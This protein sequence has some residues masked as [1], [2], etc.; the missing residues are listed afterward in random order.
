MTDFRD[1]L[2][3]HPEKKNKSSLQETYFFNQGV[4]FLSLKK[5]Y[6]LHT[7]M[8]SFVFFFFF[9]LFFF[10][11]LHFSNFKVRGCA[12][13]D[14]CPDEKITN[15]FLSAESMHTNTIYIR[16]TKIRGDR[17]HPRSF[18]FS[19]LVFFWHNFAVKHLISV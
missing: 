15:S 17:T 9:S 11:F 10:F 2:Y 7:N 1:I 18:T 8:T 12:I 5:K 13:L 19:S 3:F 4:S 16:E 6:S 14:C